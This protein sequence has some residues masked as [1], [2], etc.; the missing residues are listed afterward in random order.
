[1]SANHSSGLSQ[2]TRQ[3]NT[4]V[5]HS[6][7]ITAN[8]TLM[9]KKFLRIS[10]SPQKPTLL[11]LRE[12]GGNVALGGAPVYSLGTT[13]GGAQIAVSKAFPAIN[14]GPVA[15]TQLAGQFVFTADFDLWILVAAAGTAGHFYLLATL[16]EL[17]IADV[18]A[19][20]IP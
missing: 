7:K 18:N 8:S 2:G 4:P 11:T 14:T 13:S 1:M 6:I 9:N 19:N 3:G 5:E 10:A 15:V 17:N 20:A 12:L 16:S